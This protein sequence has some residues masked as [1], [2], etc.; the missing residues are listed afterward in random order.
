[1]RRRWSLAWRGGTLL[2]V[3]AAHAVLAKSLYV[4]PPPGATYAEADLRAGAQLMYYGGDLLEVAIA[5]VI[6]AQWY[7]ATGRDLLRTR[8]TAAAASQAP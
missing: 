1:M 2:A 3:G 5:A 6:A 4:T 7:A 8:R